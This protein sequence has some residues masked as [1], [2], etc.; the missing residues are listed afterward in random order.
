[1]NPPET[2]QDSPRTGRARR[3]G[4]RRTALKAAAVLAAGVCAGGA[5]AAAAPPAPPAQASA[6]ADLTGEDVDA[7]LDGLVPEALERTGIP[8]A[9]VSV[10]HGGEIVTARGFGDADTGAGGGEA[11]PVDA[12]E[13][14]FR[15]GSVSKLFTAT[16]VMRLVE[17]GKADLDADIADYL[18][19]EVPAAYG[20]PITLRHLL[21]H[22]A[23]FEE[24]IAKMSLPA[25]TEPDLRAYL[26]DPPEQVY[27]P[28]TVPAYSNYGNA[29]A[30]Y[31]V[32]RIA[33]VPFEEY[34][35]RNVLEP[36]GMDSS[37]FAQPLPAELE[38]RVAEGYADG[39]APAPPFEIVPAVPAGG[40]TSSAT[41][42]A[43]FMLA[44]LGEPAGEPLLAPGTLELMHAPALGEETL[45]ALAAGP[46]MTLGFF[47]QDRNGR[48]I[49]GH[50]GD[51]RYFHSHLQIYPDEGAGIFVT[52]N[53][54]GDAPTDHLDLRAEI[55][56]GFA[57]RY[58]PARDGGE[59]EAEPTAAEHAAAAEGVYET[60]R[61]SRT[62]FMN[63][64]GLVGGQTRITA[65][66]DGTIALTP[67]P[68]TMRPAVYEEVEPWVWREVGGQRLL[69]MRVEDGRVQA[70]GYD[71]AFSLLPIGPAR[72][73][74]VALPM[75]AAS[76]L[77]LLTAAVSW[78]VGEVLRR[79]AGRPRRD[80]AGRTARVLTRAGAVGAL[81]GLA[82]WTGAFL[83]VARFQPVAEETLHA[84]LVAQLIGVTAV[85]PAAAV[86]IGDL[87]RRAGWK[88][89]L[90]GALV[91]LALAGTACFAVL[92]NL[93][94]FDMTY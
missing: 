20:E 22:T 6:A 92:F 76:V 62:T 73:A 57:D 68:A 18:D 30:G 35:R 5:G 63:L 81:V 31:I 4:G 69:A 2:T 89:C 39:A 66:E 54:G 87:R 17:D 13:T 29:L 74:A 59:A 23:G 14:L 19:F 93:L 46:R 34:V 10:V 82:G 60:S 58:F 53:G 47:E 84:F 51:T 7:W 72:D 70:I 67:D 61:S 45:G 38:D 15:P 75:A 40:M 83:Q 12:E 26:A 94:S 25:G 77:V 78:P 64:L 32:E 41:D 91:L 49:L 79:R 90:G 21:T 37:T 8:G 56:D 36:A 33:G 42:M 24:R 28:G 55:M 16:A 43:R 52:L 44:Q 88:R 65:Q 11:V 50:G 85:V 48:R 86:L 71:A 1:M 9:A 3:R 80:R 27:A